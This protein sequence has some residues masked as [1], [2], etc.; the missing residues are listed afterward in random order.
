MAKAKELG[1]KALA[2][3][4]H[5]NMF[6]ALRFYRACK[7]NDIKPII[8]CEFY[9]NPESYT[10]RSLTMSGDRYYHLVL[11]AMNETGYRNLLVSTPFLH[12]RI[13]L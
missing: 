2:L 12:E 11:L 4:D 1:M 7:S 9:V 8:G 13:L 5:G 10:A 3:T 6:G